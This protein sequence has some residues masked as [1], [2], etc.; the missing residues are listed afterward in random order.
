MPNYL[1]KQNQLQSGANSET[2]ESAVKAIEGRNN[3]LLAG[4]V[5]YVTRAL[6]RKEQRRARQS[7]LSDR[8]SIKEKIEELSLCTLYVNN[9]VDKIDDAQLEELF[10]PFGTII[11]AK[12]SLNDSNVSKGFGFVRFSTPDEAKTALTSLDKKMVECESF[13]CYCTK[14]T[15]RSFSSFPNVYSTE[16]KIIKTIAIFFLD[17]A[18]LSQVDKNSSVVNKK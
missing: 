6:Y 4:K 15:I 12:V 16:K 7:T 8:D 17:F 1:Q 5:I 9:L 18:N 2:H 11:F 13:C 10:K 14:V 3:Y